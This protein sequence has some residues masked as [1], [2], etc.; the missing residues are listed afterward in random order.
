MAATTET[1]QQD[2]ERT[3]TELVRRLVAAY[4]P[5]RIYLFGSQARGQG[6][7]DSDYDLL[8]VVADDAPP[9]RQRSRLAY[10][11]LRGTATAADVLVWPRQA[12]DERLHLPASLPAT[13]L[14]EGRLVYAA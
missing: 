12:F 5:E 13:I 8:V 1:L 14:R 6:G 7:P 3:L 4:A 11:V 2:Q 9:E 10:Q